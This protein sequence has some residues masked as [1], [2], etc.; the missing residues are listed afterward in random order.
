M[1]N[2]KKT[3]ASVC[4]I[5]KHH[6]RKETKKACSKLGKRRGGRHLE[7]GSVEFHLCLPKVEANPHVEPMP[8][9]RSAGTKLLAARLEAPV[10]LRARNSMKGRVSTA[11][12]RRAFTQHS[13]AHY[14]GCGRAFSLQLKANRALPGNRG[15]GRQPSS[16]VYRRPTCKPSREGSTTKTK[17]SA[18]HVMVETTE[19]HV[20]ASPQH[21]SGEVKE[22]SRGRASEGGT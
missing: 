21:S 17:C 18:T 16:A 14:K 13:P 4:H 20:G 19:S 5:S 8:Q 15:P 1:P 11:Q 6:P 2:R 3:T 22:G 7:C 12:E 9:K 10:R